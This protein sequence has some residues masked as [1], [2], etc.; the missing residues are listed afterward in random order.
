METSLEQSS[1]NEKK[2]NTD[3]SKL[4]DKNIAESV[5][6]PAKDPTLRQKIVTQIRRSKYVGSGITTSRCGRRED[7]PRTH[8]QEDDE[9]GSQNQKNRED[10]DL[11]ELSPKGAHVLDCRTISKTCVTSTSLPSRFHH[12]SSQ[13]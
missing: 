12:F 2:S 9:S 6:R 5:V 7:E 3:T 13:L 8:H 4:S 10:G 11:V 1:S